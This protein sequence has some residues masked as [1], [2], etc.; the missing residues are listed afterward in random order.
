MKDE[1]GG[2]EI[3]TFVGFNP[4]MYSFL[5]DN[6]EHRKAKDVNKNVVAAISHNEYQKCIRRSI[7]KIQSKDHRIGT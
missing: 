4:K 3:K 7:N 5:V 2:V 6:S 1:T